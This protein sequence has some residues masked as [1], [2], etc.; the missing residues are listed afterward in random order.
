MEENFF[1][2]FLKTKEDCGNELISWQSV[3]T[4]ELVNAYDKCEADIDYILLT[5]VCEDLIM[6]KQVDK[7]LSI[8]SGSFCPLHLVRAYRKETKR[9]LLKLVDIKPLC[10]ALDISTFS[11]ESEDAEKS[12]DF[13]PIFEESLAQNCFEEL[14]SELT[15]LMKIGLVPFRTIQQT[16]IEIVPKIKIAI[17]QYYYKNRISEDWFVLGHLQNYGKPKK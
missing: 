15:R 13:C 8:C 3:A 6:S 11:K 1:E 14:N 10:I 16:L 12:D 17:F 9:K 4:I 2:E 5:G 7:L